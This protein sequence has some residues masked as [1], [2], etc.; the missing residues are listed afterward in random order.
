MI[1]SPPKFICKVY[2]DNKHPRAI[3]LCCCGGVFEARQLHVKN[4]G[5]K[6][7]GCYQ[8]EATRKRRTT[9][10]DSKNRQVTTE[11]RSWEALR[12]RCL[13]PNNAAYSHYG[14]RGIRICERWLESYTN[15]LTDM[16]RKPGPGYSL[17]R[18]NND[19]DYEPSNCRWATPKQQANNRRKPEK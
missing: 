1:L 13:N 18:I 2:G 17:D 5:I 19:G 10:G 14:G 15:F 3:Y 7:C 4:G 9:H 8:R 6:S 11:Y 16:G 12:K